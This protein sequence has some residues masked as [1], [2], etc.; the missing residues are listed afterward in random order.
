MSP[1][2]GALISQYTA[3]FSAVSTLPS[4]AAIASDKRNNSMF[5]GGSVGRSV[6]L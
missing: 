5:Y 6:T 4:G 2:T 3:T 1:G